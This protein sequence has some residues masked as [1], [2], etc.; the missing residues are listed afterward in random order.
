LYLFI[1]VDEIGTCEKWYA[2]ATCH[3]HLGTRMYMRKITNRICEVKNIKIELRLK[4][5]SQDWRW[6]IMYKVLCILCIFLYTQNIELT[7]YIIKLSNPTLN[8]S[9]YIIKWLLVRSTC[10]WYVKHS[11]D[12]S[13]IYCHNF[14]LLPAK[15]HSLNQTTW[16]RCGFS[17]MLHFF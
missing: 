15:W 14:S 10:W 8:S 9:K 11:G 17:P 6:V 4:H 7:V 3:Q 1:Y 16:G 5:F 12:N 2:S 13:S